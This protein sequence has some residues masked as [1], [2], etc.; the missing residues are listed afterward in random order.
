MRGEDLRSELY[1]R[2]K[3]TKDDG[4][5]L[6]PDREIDQFC[7]ALPEALPEDLPRA[8]EHQTVQGDQ[9]KAEFDKV[10]ERASH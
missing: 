8:G 3:D 9:G 4:T 5:E 6:L 1:A 2:G 10:D 7:L